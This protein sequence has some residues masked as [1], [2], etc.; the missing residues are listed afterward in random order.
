MQRYESWSCIFHSEIRLKFLLCSFNSCKEYEDWRAPEIKI[1]FGANDTLQTG[2]CAFSFP[3]VPSS[4]H[5]PN[6][7]DDLEED[8]LAIRPVS[9][10]SPPLHLPPSLPPSSSFN[11]PPPPSDLYDRGEDN[12]HSEWRMGVEGERFHWRRH[13]RFPGPC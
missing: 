1:C 11:P 12:S 5:Q 8:S 7:H 13:F 4:S 10:F 6:H 3:W 2:H 9:L